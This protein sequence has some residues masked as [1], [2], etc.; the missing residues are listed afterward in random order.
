MKHKLNTK[1]EKGLLLTDIIIIVAI[2]L[3]VVLIVRGVI[4]FNALTKNLEKRKTMSEYTG[5]NV[6]SIED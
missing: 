6:I 1:A 5:Y 2:F 4:G 3:A